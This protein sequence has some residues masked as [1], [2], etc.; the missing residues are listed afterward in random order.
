MK[1]P[2][3]VKSG[4]VGLA[5]LRFKCENFGKLWVVGRKGRRRNVTYFRKAIVIFTFRFLLFLFFFGFKFL[6]LQ[7][8]I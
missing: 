5:R 2:G 7:C 8:K 4:L 6:F 1:N 3:S